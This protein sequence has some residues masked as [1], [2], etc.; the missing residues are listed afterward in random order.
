MFSVQLCHCCQESVAKQAHTHL[1]HDL[2]THAY[3]SH[4]VIC[5]WHVSSRFACVRR[6]LKPDGMCALPDCGLAAVVQASDRDLPGIIGN[7]PYKK[8]SKSQH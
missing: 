6:E 2:L 1:C 5:L 3:L 4:D 7:L 8:I